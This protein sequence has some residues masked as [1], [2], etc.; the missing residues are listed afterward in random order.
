MTDS[1]RVFLRIQLEVLLKRL[2]R[3]LD[4]VGAEEL[5]TTYQKGYVR[6]LK[7]IREKAAAYVKEVVFSGMGG[8]F[9]R[10]E[11][12]PMFQALRDAVNEADTT[13]G[14]SQALFKEPD[15][16][17]VEKLAWTV[18]EKVHRVILEYQTYTEGGT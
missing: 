17:K 10:N 16:E 3:N 7:D 5:R 9:P 12:R 11:I 2:K 1:E 13:Q 15:M 8:Y 18:R 14:L 6:L 4:A